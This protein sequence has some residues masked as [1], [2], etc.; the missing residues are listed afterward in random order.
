[1]LKWATFG[2]VIFEIIIILSYRLGHEINKE[3]NTNLY[4]AGR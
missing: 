2:K 4:R 1:M 3:I